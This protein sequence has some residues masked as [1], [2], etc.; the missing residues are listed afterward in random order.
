[1]CLV[2]PFSKP[3]IGTESDEY[4]YTYG[5][6]WDK[7][8]SGLSWEILNL[9]LLSGNGLFLRET[10]TSMAE[11]LHRVSQYPHTISGY[12][13]PCMMKAV[14]AHDSY[15]FRACVEKKLLRVIFSFF[16]FHYILLVL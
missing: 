15:N 3:K 13:S 14:W 10:N 9:W 1:M 12:D 5:H 7:L 2:S 8:K 4:E 11:E 16:P 6:K